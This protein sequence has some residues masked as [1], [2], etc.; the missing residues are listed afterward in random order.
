MPE[1]PRVSVG[2]APESPTDNRTL[3]NHGGRIRGIVDV[4]P[5]GTVAA[6]AIAHAYPSGFAY[7]EECDMYW[8]S[9][10]A[11]QI[12]V[13]CAERALSRYEAGAVDPRL[14]AGLEDARQYVEQPRPMGE[15]GAAYL[16]VVDAAHEHKRSEHYALFEA[17]LW[18]VRATAEHED[19]YA[20]MVAICAMRAARY[21]AKTVAGDDAWRAEQ[22]WQARRLT[23]LLG[24]DLPQPDQR[25][26][27]FSGEA[28]A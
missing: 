21:A 10:I 7:L 22:E 3:K 6:L 26:L 12:A 20:T 24:D 27:R 16:G 9:R 23:E 8:Q 14:R 1:P 4:N 18:A 13:E 5:L 2:R 19:H 11:R 17:V 25:Q 15:R 28:A